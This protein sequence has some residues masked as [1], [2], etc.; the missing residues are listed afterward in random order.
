MALSD[1]A[2]DGIEATI[3][4]L[5]AVKKQYEQQIADLEK[6]LAYLRGENDSLWTSVRER[7]DMIA[8]LQGMQFRK[9]GT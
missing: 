8:E 9:V 4:K 7:D 2:A 3:L 1:A 5:Q 6:R